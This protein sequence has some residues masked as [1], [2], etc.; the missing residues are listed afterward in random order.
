MTYNAFGGRTLNLTQPTYSTKR[1]VD[2]H[3]HVFSDP[4]S[5]YCLVAVFLRGLVVS[6]VAPTCQCYRHF[7]STCAWKAEPVQFFFLVALCTGPSPVFFSSSYWLCCQCVFEIIHMY[8]W[9]K[10]HRSL[11]STKLYYVWTPCLL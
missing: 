3:L 8:L 11:A 9:R 7:F 6:T 10:K 4:F 2:H 1:H 5:T